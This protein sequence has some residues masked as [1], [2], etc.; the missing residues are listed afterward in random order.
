MA[1]GVLVLVFLLWI[2]VIASGVA[3]FRRL[4][5][6]GTWDEYNDRARVLDAFSRMQDRRTS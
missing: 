4:N 6:D 5:R 3:F 2:A 1:D